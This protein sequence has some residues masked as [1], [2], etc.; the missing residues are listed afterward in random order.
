MASAAD[1]AERKVFSERL[2]QLVKSEYEEI[3]RI[4]KRAGEQISENSNGIFFDVAA[5]SPQT[6]EKLQFFM[7]FCM[8]NR[9]EQDAR[10]RAIEAL[11]A[12]IHGSP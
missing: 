7:E 4:L 8:K 11:K 12:E 2:G 5:V 9:M 6:F 1:Y 10:I 3:Y